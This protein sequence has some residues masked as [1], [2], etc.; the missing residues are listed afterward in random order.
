[1]TNEY[2]KSMCEETCV[3]IE[4]VYKAKIFEPDFEDGAWFGNVAPVLCI[5]Y[6]NYI[7]H[8]YNELDK[9]DIDELC[10][11]FVDSSYKEKNLTNL[12]S[13]MK[14]TNYDIDRIIALLRNNTGVDYGTAWSMCLYILFQKE[15]NPNVCTGILEIA[16]HDSSYR[17]SV[18]K[19]VLSQNN[20]IV[21]ICNNISGAV[22]ST[23]E[24][25]FKVSGEFDAFYWGF[26]L[27]LVKYFISH[28]LST[29]MAIKYLSSD[30]AYF[31][32]FFVKTLINEK[33]GVADEATK[34]Y[35]IWNHLNRIRR[36]AMEKMPE[37][38]N[39]DFLLIG[40][41]GGMLDIIGFP[42][43]GDKRARAYIS[44]LES[45]KDILNS[46]WLGF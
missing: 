40:A 23:L 38:I 6:L 30:R 10:G 18:E 8:Y 33:Y 15:I 39:I 31:T 7:L 12:V 44:I 42:G 9:D 29:E 32:Q 26:A 24:T 41:V 2:M 13:K 1:M 17:K 43:D 4:N 21:N 20:A 14:A 36:T 25:E 11:Y 27:H 45:I 16:E 5:L 3:F 46:T 19:S 35:T 28:Q 22:K 37:K 34:C